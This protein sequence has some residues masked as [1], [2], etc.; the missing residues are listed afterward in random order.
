MKKN[1]GDNID[2]ANT[3]VLSE[4]EAVGEECRLDREVEQP[5]ASRSLAHNLQVQSTFRD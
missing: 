3:A 2:L 1:T 4:I 5:G